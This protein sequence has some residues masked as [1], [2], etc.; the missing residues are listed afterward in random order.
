MD[1][2]TAVAAA[3][4][5]NA[6]KR[7]QR[8]ITSIERADRRAELVPRRQPHWKAVKSGQFIGYRYMTRGR[9]GSWLARMWLD[10]ERKYAQS[11]LGDFADKPEGERYDAAVEKAAPFFAHHAAGGSTEVITVKQAGERYVAKKRAEEGDKAADYAEAH[12]RRAIDEDQQI[13]GVLLP[14]LTESQCMAWRTRLLEK[15]GGAEHASSFNRTL[16]APRAALNLAFEDRKVTS[17]PW[18]RALKRLENKYSDGKPRELYLDRAERERFVEA[19][20]E[21]VRPFVAALAQMPMRCGEMA[22]LQ[23]SM[24]NVRERC[25]K[26][27]PAKTKSRIV[28]LGNSALVFFQQQAAGKQ[29]D[30]WLF[31][32]AD[33]SQWDVDGWGRP[34]RA[35]VKSA[36]LPTA[37]CL[38][39]LRHSTITDLIVGGCD[40]MT[41]SKI[42]G[43]SIAMIQKTY[44]HLVPEH[45]RDHLERL[46]FAAPKK[47]VHLVA[48]AA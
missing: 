25:L 19:C 47:A 37:A 42:S 11:S 5:Q 9:P 23:V 30:D 24:V 36:K 8:S 28:P 4:L 26:L 2:T 1:R 40:L 32:R 17:R 29:P 27:P 44:G 18:R 41:V 48:V 46:V 31:S 38:Y 14:K 12:I 20:S 45:A 21:E 39:T 7:K 22:A 10:G 34:I 6:P 3:P 15:A 13:A 16:V 43:T 35:A 33:G